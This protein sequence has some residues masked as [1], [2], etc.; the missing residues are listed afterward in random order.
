LSRKY[1]PFPENE[2]GIW[3]DEEHIYIGEKSTEI[4]VDG[5][6]LIV[7]GEKYKETHGLWKFLTNPNKKNLDQET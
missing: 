7:S 5:N 1:L 2:F 6:D 4:L 3:Y